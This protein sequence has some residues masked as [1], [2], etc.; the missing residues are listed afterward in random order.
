MADYP[1]TLLRALDD[2][3]K[4]YSL[5]EAAAHLERH[6]AAIEHELE[7]AI[8]GQVP[9]FTAS[10]N[11]DVVP[12]VARHAADHLGE[13][14]RLLRTRLGA[15]LEFVRAHARRRAE[16]RF[17]LEAVLHAYRCGHKVFARWLREG[18]LQDPRT[19]QAAQSATAA[20]ADFAI[21]YTDAISTVAAAEYA[22]H[23]R[24]LADAAADQ[25]A[26]LIDLLLDGYDEA[27]ARVA[28]LLRNSGFV[29]DRHCFCVA[30]ARSVEPAEML[31]VARARRLHDTI[32][33]LFSGSKVRLLSGLR[34]QKMVMIFTD[35][36][37][38]SGWTAPR[39]S[40]AAQ[41][42]PT[43]ATVG[44]AALIG[45][46]TDAPSTAHV[47]A[48]LRE[49]AIALE[50]ANVTQR[51][52]RFDEV[53]ARRLMLHFAAEQMSG[54]LPRW[55]AALFSADGESRGALVA[56]LRAYADADMNVLK[57]AQLLGVHPNT[58]YARLERVRAATGLQAQSFASLSELLIAA[59]CRPPG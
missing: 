7:R 54:R 36:R 49:A 51:V 4:H 24:E 52:L 11:P 33:Q 55:S 44:N 23:A 41:V 38:L 46:S 39:S 9:D 25:R 16:Q 42:G 13:I 57:A 19:P 47:P 12:D 58:V 8:L 6:R 37:R 31:N 3:G 22:S 10:G 15:D 32:E 40:L 20:A 45:V 56:T 30:L 28:K 14:V 53:S 1:G 27:D 21:E 5:P 26:Q 18:A 35:L 17:P 50:L 2:L 59:D 43:L 34:D 29:A 48:A